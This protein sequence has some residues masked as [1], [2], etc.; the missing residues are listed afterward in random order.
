MGTGSLFVRHGL[1]MVMHI[2]IL[3]EYQ[4][5]GIGRAMMQYIMHQASERGLKKL[6]L[7]SSHV[8]EKLYYNLAFQKVGNAEIYIRESD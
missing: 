4:K 8:A 6:V 5:R 3:S 7:Y 1:G 2:A